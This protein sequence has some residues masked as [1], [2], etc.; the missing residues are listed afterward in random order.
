MNIFYPTAAHETT[1]ASVTGYFSKIPDV[2]AILLTCSCA[3]GKASKDSCLDL[4]VLLH[5]EMEIGRRKE[6]I[7]GWESE[8]RSNERYRTFREVGAYTHI[9]LEFIDGIFNEGYHDWTTGPDEF[10]LEI[11]NFIAYAKPLHVNDDYFAALQSRW[12]PYY[13]AALRAKRFEMVKKFFQNNLQHIPLYVERGLYFQSFNRLYHAMGEFLQA[14]FIAAR[15]YPIAYDK[16][17][18]E[19]LCDILRMPDLYKAIV[20]LMEYRVFESDEHLR[21]TTILGQLFEQ[22]CCA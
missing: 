18:R 9:D 10:E 1:A 7:A 2:S 17:I 11:G 14:L 12:L 4:A 16:W 3:R 15:I 6:I 13:D 20:E 22:H 8:H 19:Q 21:K 5:P